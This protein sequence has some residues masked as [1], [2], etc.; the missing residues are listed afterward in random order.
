MLNFTFFRINKKVWNSFLSLLLVFSFVLSIFAPIMN[1]S[2]AAE[3]YMLVEEPV[4]GGKYLI[5]GKLGGNDYILTNEKFTSGGEDFLKGESVTVSG[6]R[7]SVAAD[8]TMLWEFLI[9]EDSDSFSVKNGLKFL[10]RPNNSGGKGLELVDAKIGASY[11]DWFYDYDEKRLSTYSTGLSKHFGVLLGQDGST[12]YFGNLG[13]SGTTISEV[14]LFELDTGA[15]SSVNKSALTTAISAANA[16]IVSVAVS[17]DGSEVNTSNKWVTQAVKDAYQT[18]I[19]VAQDVVDNT[20]ATQTE[21]DSA[22]SALNNATATF[23]EAKEDG[24]KVNPVADYMLVEEPVDGGKYLIVGKL[25][26]N[27]YILTNEKF[28]SGGEDFL[29]GESV[30]VS[31]DRLSVAA[32]A[33]MLWEFL[34]NEDS[35]SFS[36]KNGLMFLVRPNNSG[37]KGLELVDA[38]IGASYSDWFYDYDEKRLSTYSTGLSKHF[39]VLLGQDGST[40]YFGNLGSSGTTISEVYLFELDTGAGPSVN[41]SALTTAISAAN[42]NIVSVAVSADG[43]EVNT[44]NKWVT[45]AV[46]DAY[47]TAITVAQDVVDNTEA[48]QTEVDSAVSALNNATATFDDAKQDGTS[49]TSINGWNE[50][51]GTWYYY[52]SKGEKLT[53]WIQ[54][55]G[56]WYFLDRDTGAM[57]TGWVRSDGKWYF[58][59]DQGAMQTG[60]I[61]DGGKWY[62]LSDSGAMRVGWVQSGG[63]WYYLSTSNGAMRVG[64]LKLGSEWYYLSTSNGAMYIGWH[65]INNKWYYFDTKSGQMYSG[66]MTPDG[67][68]VDNN[69]VWIG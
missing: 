68:L 47:Q 54:S 64:W 67:Y 59:N 29:K 23:D 15:G 8:A 48:T 55:G 34:I 58:L 11:S 13:S 6:D 40:I 14:Y 7:L 37:G 32:D 43:S 22:V 31:G 50:V 60:W 28:T 49:G 24:T 65:K 5:V 30:T 61:R 2:F 10:V 18:A 38:K 9:N 52:N 53:G 56:K 20:E 25:D 45:Q 21:V 35:E 39:G 63:K 19:T 17:A 12:I 33:T 41:K 3:Q 62:L 1:V 69:G 16:N 26:G 4:D 57:Q 27:D 66:T 44:S 46:K 51:D 36:V 42:A